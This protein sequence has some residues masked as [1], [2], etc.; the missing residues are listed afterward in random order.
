MCSFTCRSASRILE[1]IAGGDVDLTA[2][3]KREVDAVVE[4]FEAKGGRYFDA[5]D[6]ALH[7]WS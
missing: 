7:L 4:S 3:E 5:P 6:S 1:N 2:E